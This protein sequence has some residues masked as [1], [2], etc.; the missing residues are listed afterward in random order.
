MPNDNQFLISDLLVKACYDVRSQNN[1]AKTAF[2]DPQIYDIF[3]GKDKYAGGSVVRQRLDNA[4]QIQRGL[5]QTPQGIEDSFYDVRVTAPFGA[6]IKV[7]SIQEQREVASL[8][9]Q[10]LAPIAR[11][12]G[13]D[14]AAYTCE[15]SMYE[16][17]NFLDIGDGYL[18]S[19]PALVK[20]QT[21]MTDFY[22]NRSYKRYFMV[23]PKNKEQI[24]SNQQLYTNF[25]TR[26]NSDFLEDYTMGKLGNMEFYEEPQTYIH[27]WGDHITAG[28]IQLAVAISTPTNIIQLKGFSA[29]A[30]V[31]AGDHF[32]ITGAQLFNK[33]SKKIIP[34]Q[35]DGSSRVQCTVQPL[36]DD[37]GVITQTTFTAGGDGT[38][39]LTIGENLVGTGNNKNFVV[40]GANPNNIPVDS[41]IEFPRSDAQSTAN[42]FYS[43][44]G[45]L[46][47]TP[48]LKMLDTRYCE[49][50]K[51][52]D[53]PISMRFSRFADGLE[54]ENFVRMDTQLASR[55]IPR[56][57]FLYFTNV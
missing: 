47:G 4:F 42:I 13:I 6:T 46:W 10:A 27:T 7:D 44:H 9:D 12:I 34:T 18:D 30:T 50:K 22:V 11:D 26:V 36:R 56:Q 19:Y 16:I 24:I 52:K 38:L 5:T 35:A 15:E 48:P 3:M 25:N 20:A 21:F 31:N 41:V 8:E 37:K 54:S 32:T 53:F 39:T 28:T 57:A 2:M 49:V 23:S 45:L 29:G 17:S 43:D 40:A 1:F 51:D 55:W 14:T 33:Y